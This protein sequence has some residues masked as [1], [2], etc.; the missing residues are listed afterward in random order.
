MKTAI[1]KAALQH[2]TLF[3][4]V[5]ELE[6]TLEIATEDFQSYAV[7]TAASFG[8]LRNPIGA[9][10]RLHLIRGL[11]GSGKST[12][13]HTLG[14]PLVF[15]ADDW[16]YLKDPNVYA[17]KAEELPLAHRYC[18]QRTLL[19][20]AAGQDVVVANTFTT[21][22]ELEPYEELANRLHACVTLHTCRGSY[23]STHNV[24]SETMQKMATRWEEL[25]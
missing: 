8:A 13:A 14:I 7:S 12:L 9:L 20:L 2:V 18:L 24:P 25:P 17:F 5:R 3:Q 19:A 15:E 16:F 21:R 22:K 6:K 23:G 4:H 11:P 1:E 10:P